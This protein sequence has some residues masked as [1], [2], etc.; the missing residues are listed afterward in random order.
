ML[1]PSINLHVSVRQGATM[2]LC[3]LSMTIGLSCFFTACATLP[4]SANQAPP[5]PPPQPVFTTI[6]L[7]TIANA[8]LDDPFVRTPN[9]PKGRITLGGVPF[10]IPPEGKNV[11]W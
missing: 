3:R 6:D 5:P 4:Q 2:N 11:W 7:A 1:P 8:T 9:L 10:Y